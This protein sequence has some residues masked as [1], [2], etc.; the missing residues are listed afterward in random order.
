[1]QT[2]SAKGN[3]QATILSRITTLPPAGNLTKGV[4]V[5]GGSEAAVSGNQG[6]GQEPIRQITT[7]NAREGR[8]SRGRQD[9]QNQNRSRT[10]EGSLGSNTLANKPTRGKPGEGL[11]K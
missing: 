10:K 11:G 5:A 7:Q 3:V 8:T 6:H 1:M 2:T 9:N 4:K